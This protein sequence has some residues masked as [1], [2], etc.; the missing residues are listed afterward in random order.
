MRVVYNGA[1]Y[2]AN[3]FGLAL[4][5]GTDWDS[6]ALALNKLPC[7]YEQLQSNFVKTYACLSG[8]DG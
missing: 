7:L 5:A 4:S 2:A 1:G 8:Q 6:Q 3:A